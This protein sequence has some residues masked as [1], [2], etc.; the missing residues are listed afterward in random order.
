MLGW[1]WWSDFG[2]R[3]GSGALGWV[4][5]GLGGGGCGF[6]GTGGRAGVVLRCFCWA[7]NGL[8]SAQAKGNVCRITGRPKITHS[9]TFANKLDGQTILPL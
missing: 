4:A 7:G 1:T 8:I 2:E 3:D 6:V 5:N 9:L